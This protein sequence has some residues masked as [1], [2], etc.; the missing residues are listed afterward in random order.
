MDV[1]AAS[2]EREVLE[3]SATVPVVVDFWAP[4]CAPCRA[5]APILEKL[6]REYG[7][8]FRLAKVNLD[9]NPDI[10]AAIGVRSIPDVVAFR[11]GKAVARFLGAQ[12]ESRCAPSSTRCCPRPP[13][14]RGWKAARPTC[15]RRWRSTR[16]TTSRA[17]TSPS[18][19]SEEGKSDEAERLLAEVQDNAALE[20]PA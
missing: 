12:P 2:F 11:D 5:L 18:C 7:G 10:A 14:S 3:A 9:D 4:W 15:A 6:E 13:S 16:P 17:W 1:T 8:R 19:W 20:C